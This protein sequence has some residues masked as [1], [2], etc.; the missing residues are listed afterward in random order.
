MASTFETPIF[1]FF[2]CLKYGIRQKKKKRIINSQNAIN[3]TVSFLLLLVVV[4]PLLLLV[5]SMF[6]RKIIIII[7]E[8]LRLFAI[9]ISLYRCGSNKSPKI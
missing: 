4:S 8:A 5:A 7:I 6:R 1:C 3:L 9:L 2:E